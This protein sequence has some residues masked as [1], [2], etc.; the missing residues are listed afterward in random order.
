MNARTIRI[1]II[2]AV[3][4]LAVAA[5]ALAGEKA[6]QKVVE[7]AKSDLAALGSDPVLVAA[8]KAENAQGVGQALDGHRRH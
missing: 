8:V 4:A 2:T 5:T 1:M 6:P 7:F 3:M